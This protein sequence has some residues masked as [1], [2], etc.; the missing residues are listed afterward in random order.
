M[1]MADDEISMDV[2]IEGT[3]S[4]NRGSS[5]FME[6]IKSS[7]VC[8]ELR[9]QFRIIVPMFCTFLLR[10]AIPLTSLIF[11]GHIGA[12][13][14]SAIGLASVTANVTGFSMLVGIAG[15]VSTLASQA[16]GSGDLETMNVTLQRAILIVWCVVT[17]P[18]SLLWLNSKPIIIALG[19]DEQIAT[20]A[21]E[22]LALQVPGIWAVSVGQ[23][24]QNWLHAQSRASGIAMITFIVALVHPFTCYFF[25]H[26]M[27]LGYRGAA[28]A[29]SVSQLFDFC[30]LMMY[31]NVLSDIRS[32][33][34]FKFSSACF[35]DWIP[36][37]RLGLP[38]LLM[39]MEWWAAETVIFMS[40]MLPNP[41]STVG[42]MAIY[43]STLSVVFM[44]PIS[45]SVACCT[46]VGN[47]LGA[48]QAMKARLAAM[49]SLCL[50]F[51]VIVSVSIILLICDDWWVRI[52]SEDSA[53]IATALRVMPFAAIYVIC[54]GMQA[55]VGGVLRGAGKQTVAGPV[56]FVCYVC[57]G[58][59]LA[60]LLA[61]HYDK[62]IIGLVSGSVTGVGS[63]FLLFLLVLAR[64]NWTQVAEEIYLKK[65][66]KESTLKDKDAHDSVGSDDGSSS[67]L[68][69][70]NSSYFSLRQEEMRIKDQ[71]EE[72]A[73]KQRRKWKSLWRRP[74]RIKS[75][76]R[77]FGLRTSN[78]SDDDDED[79]DGDRGHYKSVQSMDSSS[80]HMLS[81][82][83]SSHN[84]SNSQIEMVSSH[85]LSPPRSPLKNAVNNGDSPNSNPRTSP[86]RRLSKSGSQD[87]LVDRILNPL[88]SSQSSGQSQA[89][90]EFE[91]VRSYADTFTLSIEESDV[92]K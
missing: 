23:C 74:L 7:A 57:L 86:N 44:F 46:R 58:V 14:L 36:F 88:F 8:T 15:A 56:V 71:L 89:E 65:L 5:W 84:N 52:F 45:I 9:D 19:E 35:K 76:R 26:Y 29:T 20:M 38:S 33:T 69:S 92:E 77:A 54:D 2:G 4:L 59:P 78:E 41:D 13:E 53:V 91:L 81:V 62:G 47:A 31:V 70:T 22:F 17:L 25:I 49:V 18:V 43:Q 85:G 21:S 28:M 82:D 51:L 73:E 11:V 61:F 12:T 72:Q 30:M 68:N 50:T 75:W 6:N 67:K 80:H 64:M 34:K 87:G 24:T 37:L 39:M 16:Y 32:T 55:S 60:V 66:Q 83:D 10:R 90:A 63:N 3:K 27:G 1:T 48:N 40:G 79:E 42:A